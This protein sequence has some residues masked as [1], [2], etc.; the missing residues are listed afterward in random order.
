[1]YGLDAPAL[2]ALSTRRFLVL[3][4]GLPPEA[5]FAQAWRTTPRVVTDPAEIARLTGQ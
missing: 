4:A 1:V 3:I 5:R 2:A